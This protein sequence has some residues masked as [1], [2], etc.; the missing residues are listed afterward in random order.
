M[1]QFSGKP[2]ATVESLK[3]CQLA[4]VEYFE[5]ELVILD[6]GTNELCL[7][8]YALSKLASA[9]LSLV[10]ILIEDNNIQHVVIL[11]ILHRFGHN[12]VLDVM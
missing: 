12:R 2:S 6:I 5:P 10:D 11:Q 4:D 3:A 1:I 8:T 7:A 9:I